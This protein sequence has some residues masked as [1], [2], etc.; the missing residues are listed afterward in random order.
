MLRRDLSF[1]IS[2]DSTHI[3]RLRGPKRSQKEHL[4]TYGETS[5][6]SGLERHFLSFL[7]SVQTKRNMNNIMEKVRLFMIRIKTRV[8]DNLCSQHIS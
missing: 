3:H 8:T 2:L 1:E 7:R 6:K 5:Q 4:S